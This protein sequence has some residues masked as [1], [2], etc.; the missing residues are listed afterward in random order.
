[1]KLDVRGRWLPILRRIP[2]KE[3]Q[4]VSGQP[5]SGQGAV[6]LS[7]DDGP[8]AET[9]PA[10]LAL[11]AEYGATATFFLSGVRAEARPDL[12]GAIVGAG[13]EVFAHGWEHIRLD[14]V[15]ADRLIADMRRCEEILGRYRA[16]PE[17]YLVRLPYAGGYRNARV[18]ATI[19][20]LWPKAQIA[21]WS[22]H[23]D[24]PSLAARCKTAEQVAEEAGRQVPAML[25]VPDLAGRVLL[26]HELAYDIDSPVRA[27]VT[28]TVTRHILDVLSQR[29]LRVTPVQPHSRPPFLSRWILR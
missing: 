20:R 21:H 4:P 22:M 10:L 5:I 8:T 9:T 27:D 1:M 17:S 2:D 13:H 29:G 11:L 6:A 15:P 26:M 16:T 19:R 18:H 3:G 25:T 28:L 12:V 24:D 23:F 7:F 14:R